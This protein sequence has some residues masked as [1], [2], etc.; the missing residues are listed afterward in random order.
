M[1]NLN[2][3]DKRE[4][5]MK[6]NK[7]TLLLVVALILGIAVWRVLNAEWHI[8]NLIPV[9]ALGLFSGSVLQEKKWAYLI[10]LSAMFLSDLGL[11]LFT[12]MDGF[13]G[14][15]QVVN[16]FALALVTF[17][18]TGLKNRSV[19]NTAIYTVSGS[20]LFFVISNFGT[21][22]GG[23]YGYGFAGLTECYAMAIP[24]Y[25]SEMATQFFVNSLLGDIIFSAIAFS[26][27]AYFQ[28]RQS[29]VQ[30]A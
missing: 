14:V 27:F 1:G 16:Y 4:K 20:L 18:G 17:L 21:Y 26:A 25:R 7:N 28:H 9:A 19:L 2:H 29:V 22:L 30:T 8:Y 10:P 3:S 11:S 12:H 5:S 6:N 23:Y 15:S 24:F 13:Y